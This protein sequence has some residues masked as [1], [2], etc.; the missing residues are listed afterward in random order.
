MRLSS[1]GQ[2][3]L[4]ITPFVAIVLIFLWFAGP[5]I[6]LIGGPAT[7]TPAVSGIGD[8]ELTQELLEKPL[9]FSR[10]LNGWQY[11]IT[12]RYRYIIRAKIV[13]RQ[14]YAETGGDQITP[15]DLA[16]ACGD[17]IKPA[18]F[19][20]FSFSMGNRQL[21]TTVEYPKYVSMLPDEYW[22]S[23]VTNNHLVFADENSLA[24]A[25]NTIVGDCVTVT[26]YLTDIRGEGPGG[27]T[28]ARTTSTSRTDEYPAGCEVVYVESFATTPC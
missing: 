10:S 12:A 4:I 9:S 13:G 6:P 17:V 21:S 1:L 14:E 18:Y 20:Y 28:Y 27:A 19:P 26:G 25:R 7:S 15:M 3:L 24:A 22:F 11:T 23:H 5:G 16:V 2:W 8:G